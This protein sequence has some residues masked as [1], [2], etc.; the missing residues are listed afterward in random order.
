MTGVPRPR[1]AYMTGQF[2][3]VSLTF[4]LRE[5][6]ALRRLGFH[7][8]HCAARRTPPEQHRGPAEREAAATTYY[9][10]AAARNPLRLLAAQAPMLKTPGRYFG[11]LA[12]A[13]RLRPPGLRGALYQLFYFAEATL[14]AAYLR[15]R[16]INHIHNHFVGPSATVSMLASQIGD[17]PFSLML[18]G[19]S[20]L[21][22]PNNWRLGDKIARARFV[23]CISHFARSQAMLSSDPIHWDKLRIIHCGVTPERYSAKTDL[24][25]PEGPLHLVFVGRLTPVKGLRVL[26]ASLADP[27]LKEVRLSVV[28]DGEDR[29]AL[30]EAAAPLGERVQFLGY[31]SQDEVAQTLAEADALILPSFAEGV[32]VVLMEALASDLPVIATRVAGVQ[33]LVE[34]GVS[35]FVVAPGDQ[36]A[37]TEAINRLATLPDHGRAMA[38]HGRAHVQAEFDINIEAA[39]LARLLTHGPGTDI[40][41]APLS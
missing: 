23:A 34:D 6:E 10:L 25:R 13:W 8:E 29:T 7:V 33:E 35:G 30:E 9:L 36:T 19:P 28:G 18:H 24:D 15:A 22:A 16:N 20:D 38:A 31:Q 3:A 32:P 14:L 12:L 41:P 5:I 2:P 40:R 1:I 4:I 11:A 26:M 27:K 17:I 21:E 37:L 39:R